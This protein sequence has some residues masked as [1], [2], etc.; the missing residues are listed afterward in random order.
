MPRNKQ[1]P[2]VLVL[3]GTRPEVIKLAPVIKELK[4]RGLPHSIVSSSQHKDLLLPFLRLFQI[5]PDHDLR[6]M[7]RNQVLN[8][9]CA[10]AIAKTDPVL[11][12]ERP[13]IV[14][15]QGD[16]T[17][18]FAGAVACFNRKIPVGHVEA[19]LRS[20]NALSP[21][22]EEMNRRLISQ[23][24]TLHFAATPLNKE[25]LI[26]E[27][28]DPAQIV[29]SGN[30]VVDSL[31][32]IVKQSK[33]SNAIRTIIRSTEG[34]KRILVTTHRRESFGTRMSSNL[35][36]LRDFVERHSDTCVLF[37]VHPNPEVRSTTKRILS[38]IRRVF[39]LEPL[40]YK[41]FI[42]LMNSAWMIVSDS[43]GVQEEAPTL[44]KALLV[45]RENTERNEAIDAGVA[46]LVG[47]ECGSLERLLEENYFDESWIRTM[48]TVKNPFG[49]GF[50]ARRIVDFII[51][52]T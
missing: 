12:A 15:V 42:A 26:N 37:P 1:L 35:E 45:L 13:D 31:R 11:L 25:T 38:G 19:G 16:T 4:K 47:R 24:A 17:T 20:G 10:R 46:K 34:L 51:S 50:A 14:L 29:V 28:V 52:R 30:P 23:L 48:Q 6:L 18:A 43:G 3:L 22:P 41:D 2:K 9:V 40:D 5:V 7:K 36:I 44:K 49:D 32:C 39:L 8:D 21:Y 27:G 33:P